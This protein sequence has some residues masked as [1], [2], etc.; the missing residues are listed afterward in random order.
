MMGEM[1][2]P[3]LDVAGQLGKRLRNYANALGGFP[4]FSCL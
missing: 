1:M 4:L 2:M 3:A